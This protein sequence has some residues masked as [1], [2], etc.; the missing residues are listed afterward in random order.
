MCGQEVRITAQIYN[1]DLKRFGILFVRVLISTVSC[2]THT[3]QHVTVTVPGL[4]VIR[5]MVCSFKDLFY[6]EKTIL[7]PIDLTVRTH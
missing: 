6:Y 7:R 1:W 3:V 4:S 5:L 2:C